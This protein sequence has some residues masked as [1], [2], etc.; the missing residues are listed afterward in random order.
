VGSGAQSF[1]NLIAADLQDDFSSVRVEAA[2][3]KE[4]DRRRAGVG[5]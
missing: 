1:M 3:L 2:A 4:E 5:K